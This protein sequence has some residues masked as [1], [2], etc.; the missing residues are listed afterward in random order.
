MGGTMALTLHRSHATVQ[1]L[2]RR[3]SAIGLRDEAQWSNIPAAALGADFVF[4]DVD[5]G[6]RE[7]FPWPAG[8]APTPIVALI[9]SEAPGR[10]KRALRTRADA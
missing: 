7:Q 8:Q 9:G 4:F 6:H 1:A 10:V 5:R 3:L 2:G